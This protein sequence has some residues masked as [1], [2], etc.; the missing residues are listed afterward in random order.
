VPHLTFTLSPGLPEADRQRTLRDIAAITDVADVSMIDADSPDP[1]ICRMGVIRLHPGAD[2]DS[3]LRALSAFPL[4][5]GPGA[6]RKLIVPVR[7]RDRGR[8]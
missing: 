5:A 3:V 7:P 6:D 1:D 8:R 4:A 2:S